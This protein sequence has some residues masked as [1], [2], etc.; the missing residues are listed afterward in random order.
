MRVIGLQDGVC[1][2]RGEAVGTAGVY[3]LL[4]PDTGL[5]RYV[6]SSHQIEKRLYAHIHGGAG[7]RST[8][9]WRWLQSL[10]VRK[11]KLRAA[12]LEVCDVGRPGSAIRHEA[13]A[14]W[15]LKMQAEGGA[16][17]NVHLTPVGHG[18]SKDSPGKRLYAE[19]AELKK[20]L[21]DV[22]AERD[23]LRVH[24]AE[25]CGATRCHAA[26]R[27]QMAPRLP[28]SRYHV[29]PPPFRVAPVVPGVGPVAPQLAE[30]YPLA[31]SAN[32]C[33]LA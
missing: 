8:P 22:E 26:P 24:L 4:D 2:R 14:R 15:I 16:D 11:L 29:V 21:A 19:F 10:G 33:T 23:A 12:I 9:K 5:V 3:G 18:N 27:H 13:E 30:N 32:R 17:L 28:D 31:E 6:G 1:C 25:L 7:K 20:R